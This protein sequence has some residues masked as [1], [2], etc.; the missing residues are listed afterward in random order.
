[1]NYL[2]ISHSSNGIT[3]Q[4]ITEYVFYNILENYKVLHSLGKSVQTSQILMQLIQSY[5]KKH[6][7]N[8]L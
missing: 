1:V 7:F 8:G 5:S 6:I 3:C 2:G 4:K